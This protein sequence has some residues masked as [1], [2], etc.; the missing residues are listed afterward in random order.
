MSINPVVLA[1]I[2]GMGL[3]TYATRAG[4]LWLM[5]RVPRSPRVERWLGAIPGAILVAIIAPALLASGPAGWL[6]AAAVALLAARTGNLLLAIAAGVTLV[7][8][9]RLL[10]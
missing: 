3:A 10:F 5:A 1:T 9:F 7:S 8:V 2:A 6:A 4:G